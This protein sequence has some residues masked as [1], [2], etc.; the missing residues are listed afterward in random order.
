MGCYYYQQSNADQ[1]RKYLS[2]ATMIDPKFHP[3]LLLFGHTFELESQ[4]DLS[5]AVYLDLSKSMPRSHL[6]LLYVGVEYSHINNPVQAEI[7]LKRALRQSNDD[8][9]FA[10]HELAIVYYQKGDYQQ[11]KETL[12]FVYNKLATNHLLLRFP[13]K[14]EPLL[15]NLGHV[16]RHLGNFEQAIDY[17]EQARMMVPGNASNCDAIGLCYSYMGQKRIACDWFQKALSIKCDDAFAM[18]MYE[19]VYQ[20]LLDEDNNKNEEQN[21]SSSSSSEHELMDTSVGRI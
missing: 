2:K 1:A 6:P 13:M 8:D 9:L 21:S 15:N 19:S 7:Y 17:H 14:W 20:Q 12:L 3:A 11:A 16:C 4:H 5:L 18:T 10:C